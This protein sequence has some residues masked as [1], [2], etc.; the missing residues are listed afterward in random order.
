MTT[1]SEALG[2]NGAQ[3]ALSMQIRH[4]AAIAGSGGPLREPQA[5]EPRLSY[6]QCPAA[7]TASSRGD[8]LPS[9]FWA[10]HEGELRHHPGHA[11]DRL[12][13][14]CPLRGD[15]EVSC[16][17]SLDDRRSMQ[18]VY[19]GLLLE[20]APDGKSYQ[21]RQDEG[22]VR[23]FSLEPPLETRGDW[24]AYRLTVQGGRAEI[25][26]DGRS[27]HQARVPG[28]ADPWLWLRQLGRRQGGVRNLRITGS[29][30]IPEHLELARGP[31][32]SGWTSSYFGEM[33]GAPAAAWEQRGAEIRGRRATVAAGRHQESLLQY[34]RPLVEDGFIEYEFYHGSSRET[35][36]P[37]LDRLVFILAPEGVRAHWLT[38]AAHDR[39][40]LTSDNRADEPACRRGPQRLELRA[41]GWNRLRI[42]LE[43]RGAVV[44]LN[45]V[46]IYERELEPGNTRIFGLFHESD[47]T[48][49]RV[50][51]V[52]YQGHWSRRLPDPNQLMVN[53]P[54]SKH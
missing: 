5:C 41:G 10:W 14:A 33:A 18:V 19:G 43:G 34:R 52:R 27:I 35:V 48:E 38:D 23:S 15:F 31:Y 46:D 21:V 32:L 26:V 42:T 54:P 9:A 8:G 2:P 25:A 3:D 45:G 6:W 12:V 29:P 11:D 49:V 17:L 47:E 1:L 36:H 44:Q 28:D 37:V 4:V 53:A 24:H 13:F 51:G 7:G 16:E 30:T 20:I 50:R 22:P 39:T 40:E